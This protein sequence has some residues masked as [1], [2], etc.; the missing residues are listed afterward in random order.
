VKATPVTPSLFSRHSSLS[1]PRATV[2]DA[3]PSSAVIN[4]ARTPWQHIADM[5]VEHNGM[6]LEV[7]RKY[8]S[9]A[10]AVSSARKALESDHS[11]DVAERLE[12]A[13][14]QLADEKYQ[15]FLRLVADEEGDE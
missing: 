9:P 11:A 5:L 6:W 8:S 14:E 10:N 12:S 3:L 7:H 13:Y 1:R 2:I 15:V 4:R